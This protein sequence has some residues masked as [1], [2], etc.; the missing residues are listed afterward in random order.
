MDLWGT[1]LRNPAGSNTLSS[2]SVS[3]TV[4]T[5][6]E[7]FPNPVSSTATF[8]YNLVEPTQLKAL[9]YDGFGKLVRTVVNG[10]KKAGYYQDKVDVSA[11]SSGIYYLQITA[12]KQFLTKKI[13]IQH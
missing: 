13:I 2:T 6:G 9:I 3:K 11:L 1:G 7:I 12:N 10:D 5:F 4:N 8:D